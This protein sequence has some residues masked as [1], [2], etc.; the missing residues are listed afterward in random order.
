MSLVYNKYC[1]ADKTCVSYCSSEP[2]KM[3]RDTTIVIAV[4]LCKDVMLSTAKCLVLRTIASQKKRTK[5]RL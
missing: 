4:V 5:L 3:L 1:L 2:E